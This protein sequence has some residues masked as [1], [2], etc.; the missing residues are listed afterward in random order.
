M[1]AP[2]VSVVMITRDRR[3]EL[4][5]TLERLQQLLDRREVRDVVVVDNGSTDGSAAA[6]PERF[7]DVRVV[8]LPE[9]LAAAGRTVGARA[10]DTDLVA[11][12]D[13]DSWWEPGALPLAAGLFATYARFGLLHARILVQPGGRTDPVCL[14]MARGRREPGT[15]GPA[16]LGH[17]ACGVV[18]R[19]EA[20]LGVGGY[21]PALGVGGEERLLA[22]DLAAAGW[23]QV[24]V[25]DVVAHHQPSP[26]REGAD[27][28]RARCRRNDCL[29]AVMRLPADRAARECGGLLRE[30]VRDPASRAELVPFLRRLPG[31]LARRR[32][33]PGDVLK[34][35]RRAE[36]TA[37]SGS[38]V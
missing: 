10:T 22:L 29:T 20:Y 35:L 24:Y 19:R 7:P 15:P 38:T 33:V 5:R 37:H 30:A 36:A 14:Q 18:V 27:R 17:L 25:E 8:A 4:L 13:D 32:T 34:Q 2:S 26:S 1:T 3:P 23:D 12:A 16:V 21:H 6:V 31:A 28:R 9:N 11:F